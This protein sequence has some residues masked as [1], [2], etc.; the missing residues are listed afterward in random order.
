MRPLE[1]RGP[2]GLRV[3]GWLVLPPG[4]EDQRPLPLVVEVHGGPTWQWGNWFHGTWHDLAQTLAAKGLPS[5]AEPARF[6]RSGQRVRRCQPLR[7]RGRLRHIIA[8]PRC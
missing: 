3:E 6:D 5:S 4:R 2:D 7:L 1:W 8:G